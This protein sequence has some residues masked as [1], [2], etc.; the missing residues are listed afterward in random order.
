LSG[1]NAWFG[2]SLHFT[3]GFSQTPRTHSLLQ[4][5]EYPFLPVFVLTHSFG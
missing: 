4:A 1:K 3:L 2:Q 5:G